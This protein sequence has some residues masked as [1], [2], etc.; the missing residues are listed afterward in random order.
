MKRNIPGLPSGEKLSKL[1]RDGASITQLARQFGCSRN[2]I[3]S[4]ILDAGFDV[5]YPSGRQPSKRSKLP[6]AEILFE[7]YQRCY[8]LS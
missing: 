1:N 4:R 5:V 7:K 2:T 6:S 8:I 3:K